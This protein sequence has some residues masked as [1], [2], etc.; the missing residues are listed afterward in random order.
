MS[1]DTELLRS[2]LAIYRCGSVTGAA[3][4]RG[5]SQPAASQH[6]AALERLVGARLF[7]RGPGGVEPTVRARELYAQVTEP[8]DAIDGVLEGIRGR[9]GPAPGRPIRFGSSPE[10]FAACVLA[11]LPG[12]EVALSAT[13]GTD[14]ELLAL[15]ERGELDVAVTSTT[16]P[17]RSASAVPIGAKRFVLVSGPGSLPTRPIASLGALADWLAGQA[18]VSYSLELPI[19]RRFWQRALGRAL[20]ERPRLVAPDLRAVLRAVELGLGVSL[21]PTFVCDEPLRSGRVVEPYP[22][23]TLVP[24]EPWFACRPLGATPPGGLTSLLDALAR[25]P[26]GAGP[27]W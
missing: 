17:R 9:A 1:S 13:F 12:R 21:L 4:H 16:P 7:V 5:I 19:T 6:L 25:P 2:F 22:V 20:P 27:S 10:Y 15:L 3:T 24:E 11:R 8:L 18:W 23:S 26:G 14:A